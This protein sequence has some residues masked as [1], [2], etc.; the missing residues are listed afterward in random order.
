MMLGLESTRGYNPM[1]ILRYRRYLLRIADHDGPVPPFR[2]VLNFPIR[3]KSLLDLLG[4]RY[5]LQPTDTT[6]LPAEPHPPSRDPRWRRILDDP[7]PTTFNIFAGTRPLPSYTLFENLDAFPRAFFVPQVAPQPP[8]SRLATAMA[9]TDFRRHAFFDGYAPHPDRSPPAGTFRPAAIREYLPNRVT[10]VADSPTPGALVLADP[11]FPG[12][13]ATL[14]GRPA[15][16]YRADDL[17]RGVEFPAGRHEV[18]FRLDPASFKIGR[19]LSLATLAALL[20]WSLLATARHRRK[21]PRGTSLSSFFSG[22]WE[23]QI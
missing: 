21:R 22:N 19:A 3:R 5:L 15:R 12:W 16:L 7:A 4:V 13:T 14:D 1:D 8:P 9:T 23:S 18:V 6:G 10:V 20:T 2:Q 17:F 11:W